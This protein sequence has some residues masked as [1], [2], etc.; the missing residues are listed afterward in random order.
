MAIMQ[1]AIRD[2]SRAVIVREDQFLDGGDALDIAIQTIRAADLTGVLEA[3]AIQVEASIAKLGAASAFNP[4]QVEM[5]ASIKEGLQGLVLGTR[6]ISEDLRQEALPEFA[7]VTSPDFISAIMIHAGRFI[8]VFAAAVA[9]DFFMIWSLLLVLTL[10]AGKKASCLRGHFD[11]LIETDT[12]APLPKPESVHRPK[13]RR[14]PWFRR[15]TK[16]T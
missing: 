13:R 9:I 16:P 4:K 5:V 6:A 15:K 2:R 1:A 3:G 8:P 7:P 11:G 14:W 12:L 10:K